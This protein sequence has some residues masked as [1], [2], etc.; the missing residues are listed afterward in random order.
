MEVHIDSIGDLR[1][2]AELI[3]AKYDGHRWQFPPGGQQTLRQAAEASGFEPPEPLDEEVSPA[4][5]T[6]ALVAAAERRQRKQQKFESRF[7][8]AMWAA[9]AQQA[10]VDHGAA[11]AEAVGRLVAARLPITRET[12]DWITGITGDPVEDIEVEVPAGTVKAAVIETWERLKMMT[13][14]LF[15]RRALSGAPSLEDTP[16]SL[17]N[18]VTL[19]AKQARELRGGLTDEVSRRAQLKRSMIALWQ[20]AEEAR[21]PRHT[22]ADLDGVDPFYRAAWVGIVALSLPP[23]LRDQRRWSAQKM[24]RDVATAVGFTPDQVAQTVH[25]SKRAAGVGQPSAA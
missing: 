11:G 20:A 10:V 23:V 8:Q 14:G 22:F 1:D 7:G 2:F 19:S 4:F 18:G 16:V 17:P 13:L 9:E 5:E 15:K 21:F 3:G 25:T 24:L 12:L 6:L